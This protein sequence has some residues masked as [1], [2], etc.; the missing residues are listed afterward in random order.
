MYLLIS[1]FITNIKKHLKTQ[2]V[3]LKYFLKINKKKNQKKK[4]MELKLQKKNIL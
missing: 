4:Y 2:P 3:A 1:V